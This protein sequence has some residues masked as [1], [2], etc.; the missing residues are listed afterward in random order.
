MYAQYTDIIEPFGIDE[1]WLDVTGSTKLFGSAE[2]IAYEIKDTMKNLIG[3]TISVGVSFN[4]VFAKLGSD[5]K[6]PDAV[7]VIPKETFRDVIWDLPA[8]DMLGIGKSTEKT[9]RRYGI[10]TLRDLAEANPHTLQLRLGKN[11]IFLWRYANGLDD[12]PVSH[13]N[14][15][16]PIKSIGH[17]MTCTRDLVNDQDAWRIFYELSRDI[18][19]KLRDNN[20]MARGIQITVRDKNL[21]IRQ[22]QQ[23]LFTPTQSLKEIAMAANKIFLDNYEWQ[24]SIRSLTIRAINLVC[25]DIPIQLDFTTD[26][27]IKEKNEKLELAMKGI[28]ERENK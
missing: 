28:T 8:S 5:M 16:A 21:G 25:S 15:K 26:Y 2:K 20:L 18:S 6:K 3:L 1:C 7:T 24:K 22:F 23:Q 11:S 17:G 13:K 12:S 27:T 10:T 14:Y 4:K 9:L 19:D